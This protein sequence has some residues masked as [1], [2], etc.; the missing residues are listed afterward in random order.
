VSSHEKIRC[1]ILRS[2]KCKIASYFQLKCI[3]KGNQMYFKV[4]ASN[5]FSTITLDSRQ[6]KQSIT[7]TRYITQHLS[8]SI[9]DSNGMKLQL[10]DLNCD[11]GL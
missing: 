10:Y 8:Y 1:K 3:I 7:H 2:K 5:T 9:I 4:S 6:N 11:T